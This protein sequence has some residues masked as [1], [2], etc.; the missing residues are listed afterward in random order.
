[1]SQN[2]ESGA[3]ANRY[4][5]EYGGK[6]AAALGA[7]K[8]RAGSNECVLNGEAISIKCA[9]LDTDRVG[10]YT[11]VLSRI[12]AVLGAFETVTNGPY[13]VYRL[14]KGQF[15]DN[16]VIKQAGKPNEQGQVIRSVFERDGIKV[17]SSLNVD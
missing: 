17:A 5:R 13:D 3:R 7:T 9:K 11:S 15:R 10:V 12:V 16:M 8:K 1:M 4:G 14:S 2:Q 6:I